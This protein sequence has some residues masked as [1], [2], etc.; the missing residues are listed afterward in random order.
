MTNTDGIRIA[1]KLLQRRAAQTPRTPLMNGETGRRVTTDGNALF[2]YGW[3]CVAYFLDNDTLV[4][5]TDRYQNG[6]T[7]HGKP[8]YSPTTDAHIGSVAYVAEKHGFKET[9]NRFLMVFSGE[10]REF[11]VFRRDAA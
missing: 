4:I 3:W 11:A 6:E 7:K 8:I 9:E 10:T 2:S 1:T 5:T